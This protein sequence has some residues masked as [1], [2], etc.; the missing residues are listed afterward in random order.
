MN[1]QIPVE[2]VAEPHGLAARR[3]VNLLQGL[4]SF[5]YWLAGAR[6]ST[7]AHVPESERERIAVLGSSVLIP[8]LLAFFGMYLYAASRFSQ[9]RPIVTLIIALFWAFI[10]MNVDRIL[11]ATY[12]PFQSQLRKTLQVF[13]RVGL[14]AVISV[15]ITFPFCL[16]QYRGAISERLQSEYR[17]KLDGAQ[18]RERNDRSLFAAADAALIEDL[19]KKLEQEQATGPADPQLFAEI[20]AK[21]DSLLLVDGDKSRKEALEQEIGTALAKWKGASARLAELDRHLRQEERGTLTPEL[22]GT[23]KPGRAA[24]YGELLRDLELAKQTEQVARQNY[25]QLLRQAIPAS[26]A[27]NATVSTPAESSR[28]AA[29]VREAELRKA[30]IDALQQ[31]VKHAEDLQSQH[32]ADHNLRHQ[33]VIKNY[34]ARASGIFDPMEET[35][36]LFKVIFIPQASEEE[37]DQVAGRYKWIAALFQFSI[38]FATLFF[39]DLIAILSKV[40]SRPGPYDVLVDF[41]EF[42][43]SRNLQLFKQHYQQSVALQAFVAST[44]GAEVADQ[45][46]GGIDLRDTR[47]VAHFLLQAYGSEGPSSAQKGS[48]IRATGAERA[49]STRGV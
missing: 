10:I 34:Q 49:G 3:R 5:L 17:T 16:H 41:P 14:A 12:R 36:G 2:M 30:R 26:Q 11:L 31:S 28:Q 6:W 46:E 24:K 23:G 18:A 35:I 40:M 33:P 4:R 38:V 27:G 47:A 20:L 22:G 1:V 13:F 25:N 9:P 29:F 21:K 19:R 15:A 7:L 44:Q 37:A 32:L 39:L 42:V 48:A 45:H 8:T 43:S